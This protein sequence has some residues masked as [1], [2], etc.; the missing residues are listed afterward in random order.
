MGIHGTGYLFTQTYKGEYAI[1][2]REK[3]TIEILPFWLILKFYFP[4]GLCSHFGIQA[5]VLQFY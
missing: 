3:K 4:D 1:R 5:L 2:E